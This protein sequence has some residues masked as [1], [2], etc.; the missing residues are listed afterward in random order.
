MPPAK[1]VTKVIKVVAKGG[2]ANPSPP[3]GPAL[4]QAGVNIQQ[5]CTAFNDKTKGRMGDEVPVVITVYEDRSFTFVTKMPPASSLIKKAIKLEKGSGKPN[6]EKVGV[7]PKAKLREI[8]ELKM[9]DLNCHDVE[10][11]MNIIAGQARQMGVTVEA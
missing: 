1:K 5:F 7:L 2:Q 6:T 3:L 10:A 9:P 4:G 8:A 11:A